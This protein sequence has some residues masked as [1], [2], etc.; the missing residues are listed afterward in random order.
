MLVWWRDVMTQWRLY[1]SRELV[2]KQF[3]DSAYLAV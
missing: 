3:G 2:A 1:K